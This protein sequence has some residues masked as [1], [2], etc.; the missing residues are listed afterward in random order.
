MFVAPFHSA[1]VGRRRARLGFL[2]AMAAS[3]PLSAHEPG[4]S[5]TVCEIDEVE[6]RL[7]VG[8][9]PADLPSLAP[10]ADQAGLLR[11]APSLWALTGD[12]GTLAVR[13]ATVTRDPENGLVLNLAFGRPAGSHLSLRFAAFDRLPAGHRDY[14][15]WMDGGAVQAAQLLD[16][17][18]PQITLAL[19]AAGPR[20][21][22]SGWWS[23]I[24]NRRAIV[25]ALASLAGLVWL[26]RRRLI[27]RVRS[28]RATRRP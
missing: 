20:P 8:I 24:S 17:Q 25:G 2:L 6:I 4:L 19:P 22:R 7:T 1:P 26:L 12:R 10:A 28:R 11:A 3:S 27:E 5:T 16:A 23:A 21:A 9:S 18:H 13:A 14:F 15:S